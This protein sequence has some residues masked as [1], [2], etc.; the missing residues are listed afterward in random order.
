L[1]LSGH[2]LFDVHFIALLQPGFPAAAVGTG[3]AVL[4]RRK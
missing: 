4:Q 1:W 2:D 3:F